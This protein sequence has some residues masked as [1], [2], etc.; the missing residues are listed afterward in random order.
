MPR[1]TLEAFRDHGD[2]TPRLEE[3]LEQARA[4]L[5]ELGE[6]GISLDAVSRRLE[7]EGVKKFTEPFDH[8]HS[9][10]QR[11]LGVAAGAGSRSRE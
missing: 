10:L 9:E 1:K 5:R 4:V 7:E 11:K 6:L 8:L 3:N 2:P